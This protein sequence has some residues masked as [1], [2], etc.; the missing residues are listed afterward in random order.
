MPIFHV[1]DYGLR[2][3]GASQAVFTGGAALNCV[4]SARLLEH[5]D[6]SWY[7]RYLNRQQTRLHLW[8]P[9]TPGDA[10]APMGAAFHFAC[11]A[12][13]KPKARHG[14]HFN[15]FL[16]GHGPTR[17]DIEQAVAEEPEIDS[18]C[19][20]SSDAPVQLE[21]LADLMAYIVSQDGV[22]GIVQGPAETGPRALGHR[23]I[24][25][26]PT[27][28]NTLDVLN[29][30]VKFRERIR[31]LA[32]MAT[33]EAA[34]H[35][36]KLADGGSDGAFD[37]YNYMVLTASARP[38]S[39]GTDSSRCSSR[40]QFQGANCPPRNRPLDALLLACLGS[41]VGSGGVRQHFAE[42]WVSDCA[43]AAASVASAQEG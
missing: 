19:V 7:E 38:S 25:A 6:E 23:S 11:L 4:A 17:A 13:A 33:L 41:A 24:L 2:C 15:P 40:R 26:N 43:N 36:F 3:T 8:V 22:I 16:C 21:E 18:L 5:F 14:A 30:R 1:F 28:P 42:C 35:L 31:P 39:A 20:G 27:N 12:G 34:K 10:G 9:P 29:A 37:A 32:P